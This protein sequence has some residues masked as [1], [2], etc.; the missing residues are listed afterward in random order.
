MDKNSLIC[1][2]KASKL[3]KKIGF[4]KIVKFAYCTDYRYK[5]K[6]ISFEEE[7]D[8]KDEGREN[9]IEKIPFGDLINLSNSNA[10]NGDST[11]SAPMHYEVDEWFRDKFNIYI[12]IAPE[13]LDKTNETI[14]WT[15]VFWFDSQNKKYEKIYCYFGTKSY[16][17]AYDN[18]I[19]KTCEFIDKIC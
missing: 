1:S 8:L 12:T 18:A 11:I 4:K 15:T 14:F 9:E 7:L 16:D 3:L 2:L 19:I 6:H 13:Y 5:G 17:K 10:E